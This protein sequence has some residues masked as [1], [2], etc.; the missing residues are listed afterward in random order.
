MLRYG[1]DGLVFLPGWHDWV[2]QG[3]VCQKGSGGGLNLLRFN[4]NPSW[5][6]RDS[7]H[8]HQ[9]RHSCAQEWLFCVWNGV[10]YAIC[11]AVFACV[12]VRA[13]MYGKIVVD[14][15]VGVILGITETREEVLHCGRKITKANFHDFVGSTNY[16]RASA[17]DAFKEKSFNQFHV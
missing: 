9:C 15:S 5:H 13:C 14:I 1:C 10:P 17:R 6:T 2:S 8:L 4:P 7:L 11:S 3:R 16:T 12:R